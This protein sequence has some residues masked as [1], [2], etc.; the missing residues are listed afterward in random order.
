MQQRKTIT[1]VIVVIAA[2]IIGSL[3]KN[4]KVGF[5][6]GLGLGLLMSGLLKSN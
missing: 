1:A 3:L 4:V 2:I 6:L 5:V